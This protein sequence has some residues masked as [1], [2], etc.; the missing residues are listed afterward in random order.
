MKDGWTMRP[1]CFR[2]EKAEFEVFAD[3]DLIHP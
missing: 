2:L 3:R 1:N